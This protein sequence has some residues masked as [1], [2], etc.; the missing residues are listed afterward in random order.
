MQK[1]I[2]FL[3]KLKL[4]NNREWFEANKQNYIEVKE[5]FESIIKKL[6]EEIHVFDNKI[7]PEL[8]PKDCT[9]RIYKDVRFSK[10]KV[11]YKIC[12]SASINPGGKKSTIAGY[13][14]HL[15]P[16]AS[17]IA[18]GIYMP[19]PEILQAVRQ[20]IDYNYSPLFKILNSKVFKKYFNGIDDED[21]LKNPPKGFDKK[22][23]QIE[24]LKN[25]HFIVSHYFTNKDLIEKG[26]VQNL[27]SGFK[28]MHPFLAYLRNATD[29]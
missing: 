23:P 4:N 17:F 20:E 29:Q 26:S 7:S 27:I 5:E 13:Y 21:K 22:H 16:N 9:F 28:A 25:K 11:P 6:I 1:I 3:E 19:M 24:L 15:E 2:G 18:G 12:M 14:F 8:K 10:D